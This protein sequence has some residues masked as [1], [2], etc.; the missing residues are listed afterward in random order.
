MH[1]ERLSTTKMR[2]YC[3]MLYEIECDQ[4]AETINGQRVPR[5]RIRFRPGLNTVLGDKQGENSIG[6]STFLLAVDFCFGGGDYL[7]SEKTKITWLSLSETT[8]SSSLSS[9]ESVSSII[10]EARWTLTMSV[11]AMRIITRSA[12]RF[13]C[14]AFRSI[15]LLRIRFR[16]CSAASAA[17]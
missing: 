9:L 1:L 2:K 14:M 7:D 10:P 13:R 6:K 16:K 17:W 12:I 5:G 15:F 8:L 11:Y 3:A 4:F